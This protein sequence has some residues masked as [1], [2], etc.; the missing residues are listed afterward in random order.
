LTDPDLIQ[1]I[2][3]IVADSGVGVWRPTG[4]VYT[5]T[6][7]GI[8]YGPV[9]AQTPRGVGLTRYGRTDYAP[10][11]RHAV[12]TRR[13]QV[14]VRGLPNNPGDADDLAQAVDDAL[15]GLTRTAGIN[16]VDRQSGPAPLGTDG[17]GRSELSLNYLVILED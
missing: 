8:Y 10:G 17:N 16:L 4:P 11:D 3:Q 5:T 9:G 2:A 12:K 1:A 15:Q 6:E 14:R 7:T 13:V